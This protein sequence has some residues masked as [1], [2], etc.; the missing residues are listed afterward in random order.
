MSQPQ[1][2]PGYM[3]SRISHGEMFLEIT[4]PD[5]P[6]SAGQLRVKF[7]MQ[8]PCLFLYEGCHLLSPSRGL[9][10]LFIVLFGSQGK[11]SKV[12][13]WVGEAGISRGSS[14]A[15]LASCR[16]HGQKGVLLSLL[17]QWV[18]TAVLLL[19]NMHYF[20][21]PSETQGGSFGISVESKINWF[22]KAKFLS[23]N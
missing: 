18:P 11:P 22:P 1:G 2:I 9:V 21:I 23:H 6:E 5:M 16:L 15:G 19:T 8:G 3:H 10:Y 20:K 12:H 7:S 17:E 13:V 14:Q 4:H